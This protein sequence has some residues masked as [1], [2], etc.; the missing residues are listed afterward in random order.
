MEY[1]LDSS[2]IFKWFSYE[3]EENVDKAL[4][5]LDMYRENKLEIIIPELVIYEVSNALRFNN[6]FSS[7]ETRKII[8]TLINLELNV[9]GLN[10]KVMDS[11][12]K[13][14]YE[15]NITIYDAVFISLSKIMKVP[16]ISAN[17][18]HHKVLKRGSIIPLEDF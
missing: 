9:I 14:A 11:A 12:I 7:I 16:L 13:I 4:S 18:R 10:S 1:I 5:I 17:P 3:N 15:E 6:N 8:S 2:V